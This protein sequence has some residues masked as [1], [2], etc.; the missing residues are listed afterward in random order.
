MRY[1]KRNKLTLIIIAI[2]LSLIN[3]TMIVGA[4]DKSAEIYED[5][6]NNWQL[7]I[8]EPE[9]TKDSLKSNDKVDVYS[10]VLKN[11]GSVKKDVKIYSFTDGTVTSINRRFNQLKPHQEAI[12]F[13]NFPIKKGSTN[14]QLLIIWKDPDT[15]RIKKEEFKLSLY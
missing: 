7:T 9:I 1:K 10:L 6:S 11:K 2:A 4:S 15:G 13:K 14:S 8:G 12:N 3:S 5:E